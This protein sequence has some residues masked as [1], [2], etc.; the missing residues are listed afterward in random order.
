[1]CEYCFMEERR[2]GSDGRRKI[3]KKGRGEGEENSY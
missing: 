3:E 2:E 1:L